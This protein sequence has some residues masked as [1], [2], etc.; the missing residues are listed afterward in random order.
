[1]GPLSLVKIKFLE[2]SETQ[3]EIQDLARKFCREEIIPA[4]AQYDRAGEY[5]T[6][7]VKKAWALGFPNGHI[8]VHCGNN[9]TFYRQPDTPPVRFVCDVTMTVSQHWPVN[10]QIKSAIT[11]VKSRKNIIILTIVCRTKN[12]IW[13][14]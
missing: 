7:I 5:P 9:S 1:M 4:A 8:P 13:K 2:L 6:E 10:F 11:A 14:V 3:K 12:K